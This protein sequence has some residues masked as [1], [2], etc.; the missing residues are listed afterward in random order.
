MIYQVGS[1]EMFEG[2][3]FFPLTLT[4]MSAMVCSRIRFALWD[5]VPFAVAMLIVKSLMMVSMWFPSLSGSR[6][7]SCRIGAIIRL[8]NVWVYRPVRAAEG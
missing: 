2:K 4:P 1:P 7:C 5:P 3:R 8:F 6:P